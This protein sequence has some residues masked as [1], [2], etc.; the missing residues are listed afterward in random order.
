[1]GTLEKGYGGRRAVIGGRAGFEPAHDRLDVRAAAKVGNCHL[2]SPTTF[3]LGGAMLLN[4]TKR[5][6]GHG[7]IRRFVKHRDPSGECLGRR[8]ALGDLNLDFA[9][10]A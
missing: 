8:F 7:G 3:G 5:G 10:R 2:V 6:E 9:V 4:L 1:M